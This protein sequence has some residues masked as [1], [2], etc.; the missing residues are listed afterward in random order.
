MEIDTFTS[1]RFEEGAV[2]GL[3]LV[4]CSPIWHETY[5]FCGDK[6]GIFFTI[7]EKSHCIVRGRSQSLLSFQ[8]KRLIKIEA[9]SMQYLGDMR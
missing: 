4:G 7:M 1:I 5:A 2:A 3:N 6:G 9:L 8:N